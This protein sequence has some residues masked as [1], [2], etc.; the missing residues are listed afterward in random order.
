VTVPTATVRV[1]VAARRDMNELTAVRVAVLSPHPVIEAGLRSLLHGRAGLEVVDPEAA[2]VVVVDGMGD[3]PEGVPVVRLVAADAPGP[4]PGPE[5]PGG[6]VLSRDASEAALIAAVQAAAAGLLVTDPDLQLVEP[7]RVPGDIELTPR[8]M[9]VLRLLADGLPN[10]GIAFALG[11][12]DHTAKFH[13][14][15]ILSKLDAGSRTEAVTIAI[16]RGLLPL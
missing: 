1:A 16:R 9:E 11:I 14:G 5:A 8:E 13:V 7:T 12:S 4:I 3:G 2:E 10:K 6:A 15:Q